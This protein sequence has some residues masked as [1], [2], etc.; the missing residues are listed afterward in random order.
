MLT[1]TKLCT[2]MLS[3]TAMLEQTVKTEL[4]QQ[5]SQYCTYGLAVHCSRYYVRS[6]LGLPGSGVGLERI[7][8]PSPSCLPWGRAGVSGPNAGVCLHQVWSFSN[9]HRSLLI[10][11][12][13]MLA[14]AHFCVV[15]PGL[16]MLEQEK[17]WELIQQGRPDDYNGVAVHPRHLSLFEKAILKR[18]RQ[19]QPLTG[20]QMLPLHAEPSGSLAADGTADDAGFRNIRSTDSAQALEHSRQVQSVCQTW[21]CC[22]CAAFYWQ[23]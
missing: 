1:H 16:S 7:V 18:H 12:S 22:S 17:R 14:L 8:P 6:K 5:G 10:A 15:P 23:H 3:V 4:S 11:V 2:I 21:S 19:Y 13:W 9:T 20:T